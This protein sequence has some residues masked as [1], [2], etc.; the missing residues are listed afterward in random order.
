MRSFVIPEIRLSSQHEEITIDR[1]VLV[2]KG[3]SFCVIQHTPIELPG[4]VVQQKEAAFHP[5]SRADLLQQA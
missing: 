3:R 2:M 1:P 5:Q 4:N